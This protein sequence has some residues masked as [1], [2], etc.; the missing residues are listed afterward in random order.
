MVPLSVVMLT[1]GVPEIAGKRSKLAIKQAY[2][3]IDISPLENLT[4]EVTIRILYMVPKVGYNW[5]HYVPTKKIRVWTV[6]PKVMY[7]WKTQLR[8]K[9]KKGLWKWMFDNVDLKVRSRGI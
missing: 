1:D 3:K 2:S 8:R 6:E 5:R 7:G 4:R 9:G